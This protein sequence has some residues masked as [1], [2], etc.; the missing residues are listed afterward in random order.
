MGSTPARKQRSVMLES[1][2]MVNSE[3]TLR[4]GVIDQALD[5]KS[6][7]W[8]NLRGSIKGPGAEQADLAAFA[9]EWN[10]K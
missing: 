8:T 5:H 9:P 6:W 1:D 7:H 2:N 4:L 3:I 10:A